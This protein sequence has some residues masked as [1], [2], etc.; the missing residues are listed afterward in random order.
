MPSTT[1]SLTAV[2]VALTPACQLAGVRVTSLGDT[3]H[4]VF[5]AARGMLTLLVGSVASRTV[6][7][8]VPSGSLTVKLVGSNTMPAPSSSSTLTVTSAGL[9]R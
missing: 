6:K 3:V 4:S 2:T 7:S 9:V 8:A 1:P 5:E